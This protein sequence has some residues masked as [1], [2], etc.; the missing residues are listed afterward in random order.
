MRFQQTPELSSIASEISEL[1][2]VDSQIYCTCEV[3]SCKVAASEKKLSKSLEE[4]LLAQSGSYA[5]DIFGPLTESTGRKV[6]I[7]LIHTL[8]SP[9]HPQLPR[10]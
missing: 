2:D 10:I 4:G 6:F 3:Y 9:H 7:N 5:D 8:V 1:Q